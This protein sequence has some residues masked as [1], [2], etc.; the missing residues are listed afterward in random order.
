MITRSSS[1]PCS[2][3]RPAHGLHG[4]IR[5]RLPSPPPAQGESTPPSAEGK[6]IFGRHLDHTGSGLMAG[7]VAD[8]AAEFETK[9]ATFVRE[10]RLYGA[11]AGVVHGG[12]FAWSGGTGFADMAA[13]R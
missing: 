8:G 3:S 2:A 4:R 13:G 6:G 12:E 1:Q 11:S 9:L 7:S 5:S 10:N